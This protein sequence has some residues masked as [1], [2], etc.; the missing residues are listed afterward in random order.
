M[1][2][3]LEGKRVLVTGAT[4]FIGGRLV[5]RLARQG[6]VEIRV[7]VRNLSRL[8]RL[9]RFDLE[10]ARGDVTDEASVRSAAEGC[11]VIVNCAYGSDGSDKH[12]TSVNVDGVRHIV[13]AAVAGGASRVVHLSTVSVYGVVPEGEIDEST[14]RRP[15]SD[16]YSKTK[17]E[18]EKVALAAARE[19]APVTVV[20]PTI[21]YGPFAPAWTVNAIGSLTTH[22]VM[23]VDG[24]QG[25]CNAVYI[26]DLIDAM[27]AA[28]VRPEAVGEAFLVSG[29][30]PVTWKEFY[31]RYEAMLGFSS[32]I[33][34]D[35]SE[36]SKYRQPTR[37]LVSESLAALGEDFDL[38]RRIL[39][40]REPAAVLRL[41][42]KVVPERVEQAVVDRVFSSGAAPS[43]PGAPPEKPVLMLGRETR[44]LFAAK[45]VARIDKARRLLGYA[46]R[47]SFDEGMRLTEAWVRWANL[48]PARD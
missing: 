46:P 4:G 12:Q 25:I 44:Q 16:L 20:Q 28:A 22:R 26:D 24:G 37:S 13:D 30:D 29:D 10:V 39:D 11:D 31:G 8:A 5:E 48:V 35:E 41:A 17:A 23:L 27:L 32:T 15:A 3:E 1:T 45:S 43:G 7:L 14:P 34:V 36:V 21:V 19:G 18:G 42:R 33:E 6:G 38:R 47:R 40:S 9:G 2:S